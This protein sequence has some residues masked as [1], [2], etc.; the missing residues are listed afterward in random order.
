MI[1]NN[2]NLLIFDLDNTLYNADMAY[3]VALQRVG[4][5]LHDERY[6]RARSAVKELLGSDHVCSRNRML[7]FKRIFDD[8]GENA[9]NALLAFM[10]RYEQALH[11]E[12][13]RQWLLLDRD[14][15]FEK[16]SNRYI[17]ILLTN[18]NTRTQLIKINAI[19]ADGKY[20]SRLITSEEV[21]C[22]KPHLKIFSY[23]LSIF[24]LQ[25]R[26]CLMIGDSI[27]QDIR[28]SMRLGMQSLVTT[29][30]TQNRQQLDAGIYSIEKLDEL[31]RLLPL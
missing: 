5:G 17:C 22:E 10:D 13:K 26:E 30:F 21:G 14:L 24:K 3:S 4:L 8:N 12:I 15:L 19:D 28:P 1:Y 9:P 20:F 29:E 6:L 18:E 11:E 2:I 23:V 7:Y 31:C 27:E 16:L 25:P